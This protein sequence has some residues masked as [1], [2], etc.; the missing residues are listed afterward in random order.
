MGGCD[1]D[2]EAGEAGPKTIVMVETWMVSGATQLLSFWWKFSKI[3]FCY[4]FRFENE[5]LK[6]DTSSNLSFVR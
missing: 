2:S 1:G 5:R 6:P 3:D 4:R